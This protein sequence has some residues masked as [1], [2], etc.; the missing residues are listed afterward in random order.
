MV[1]IALGAEDGSGAGTGTE[2]NAAID[3][4]EDVAGAGAGAGAEDVAS[5]GAGA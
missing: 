4:A 5:A 1:C 2:D 3:C